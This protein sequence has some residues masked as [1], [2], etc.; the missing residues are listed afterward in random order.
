MTKGFYCPYHTAVVTFFLKILVKEEF[1]PLNRVIVMTIV[2]AVA[3]HEFLLWR[4]PLQ[5]RNGNA[6]CRVSGVES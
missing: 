3:R 1:P 6:L 4:H 2:S 5:R